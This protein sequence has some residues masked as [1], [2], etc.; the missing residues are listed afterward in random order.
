VPLVEPEA[1]VTDAGTV[2]SDALLLASVTT[3]PAEGAAA[4]SV[5]VPVTMLPP[6]AVGVD[7]VTALKAAV[8]VGD[9]EEPPHAAATA[10][11][12]RTAVVRTARASCKARARL[13]SHAPCSRQ[14]RLGKPCHTPAIDPT[15][16]LHTKRGHGDLR[17]RRGRRSV[18]QNSRPT[19]VPV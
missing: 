19:S 18:A 2:A 11:K 5:I 3:A 15:N 13:R 9:V 4:V 8:V 1:I 17:Q 14:L 16:F 12:K 7:N 10:H 6:D